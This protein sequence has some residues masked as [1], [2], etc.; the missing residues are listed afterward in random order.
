MKIISTHI[1]QKYG[2]Y[3]KILSKWIYEVINLSLDKHK[4]SKRKYKMSASNIQTCKEIKVSCFRECVLD[5]IGKLRLKIKLRLNCEKT[6]PK[7][8]NNISD[9]FI[10]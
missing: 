10:F 4:S 9:N 8:T 6:L 2:F 7:Q 5:N 1:I 3:L